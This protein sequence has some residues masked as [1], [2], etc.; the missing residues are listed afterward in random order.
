MPRGFSSFQRLSQLERSKRGRAEGDTVSRETV[1][2]TTINLRQERTRVL[3]ITLTLRLKNR[4]GRRGLWAPWGPREGGLRR[5]EGGEE[6]EEDE[7]G[8]LG[9]ADCAVSKLA[10]VN[11]ARG[12]PPLP[13]PYPFRDTP[14]YFTT[15]WLFLSTRFSSFLFLSRAVAPML[16]ACT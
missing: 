5:R 2:F 9:T 10:N 12:C 3:V 7:L 15:P 16:D 13:P 1:A 14:P 8:M 11:R 6:E 4:R